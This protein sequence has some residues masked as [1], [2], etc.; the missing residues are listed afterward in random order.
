MAALLVGGVW[1]TSRVLATGGSDLEAAAEPE[2]AAPQPQRQRPLDPSGAG[3]AEVLDLQVRTIVIDPGH[4]GRDPG[5]IGR[6]RLQEKEVALDVARR[7]RDRLARDG[8]L[9]VLLTREADEAV[10]LE[11]RVAFA[12]DA[13]ADLFVSI[14]V[15]ALPD[16]ALAPVETY[17]FG[18]DATE[19]ARALAHAENSGSSFSVA[20]F[21]AALRRAATAV[22]LQESRALAEAVQ[23]SLVE[24]RAI[25]PRSRL[26][27][28]AKAAPF[29]VL[30]YTEAPAVLAE[31]TALSN[32]SEESR[33]R[34]PAYREAVATAL[35]RGILTYLRL[36]P[37]PTDAR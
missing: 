23:A 15:N 36:S 12:N 25:V 37:T 30:L 28:G 10:S 3:V 13:E 1:G 11:E 24:E 20:E 19:Q 17:F 16:T 8:D 5:A 2:R 35:E 29:N 9:H 7:L 32:P 33:L 22:K 6:G 34:T 27:W 14:H 21:N 26:D 31:I 18:V 4:G